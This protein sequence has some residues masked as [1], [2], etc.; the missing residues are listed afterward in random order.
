MSYQLYR[1]T[2][3]GNSLQESLDELIQVNSQLT[4]SLCEV[5]ISK[6]S[7]SLG[8]LFLWDR[9]VHQLRLVK[10][11]HDSHLCDV[12]P[13]FDWNSTRF[14]KFTLTDKDFS[15]CKSVKLKCTCMGRNFSYSEF[16]HESKP[17]SFLQQN[18]TLL[19][20]FG[21]L[22]NIIIL[23]QLLLF[24]YV[25]GWSFRFWER[26]SVAQIVRF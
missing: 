10:E 14:S 20:L 26:W 4:C 7:R 24:E 9:L 11:S 13:I 1:N 21:E 22:L 3:L 15:F 6:C 18:L 19:S 12:A 2:T 8:N 5:K 23:F 17:S 25:M 16:S